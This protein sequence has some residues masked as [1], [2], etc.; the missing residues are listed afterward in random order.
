MKKIGMS[1]ILSVFLAGWS[2][3]ETPTVKKVTYF[4]LPYA[5]YHTVEAKNMDLGVGRNPAT[6]YLGNAGTSLQATSTSLTGNSSTLSL[7]GGKAV[8]VPNDKMAE[9]GTGSSTENSKVDF[10]QNL[11]I[12]SNNASMNTLNTDQMNIKG[13]SLFNRAFPKCEKAGNT[14]K[15]VR[16]KLGPTDCCSWYLACVGSDWDSSNEC[17]E[18]G[19]A[20][21]TSSGSSGHSS[22]DLEVTYQWKLI[23]SSTSQYASMS[24]CYINTVEDKGNMS[25]NLGNDTLSASYFASTPCDAAHVNEYCQGSRSLDQGLGGGIITK[26]L[27]YK[28]QCQEKIQ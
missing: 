21:C 13:L 12:G 4:P 19:S 18:N 1:F 16:L 15:W 27:W 20:S 2:M 11:R 24:N 25:T 7:N 10:D 5:A 23:D 17:T 26:L 8:F 3:A 6:G 22:G 9:I 28:Y 14:M